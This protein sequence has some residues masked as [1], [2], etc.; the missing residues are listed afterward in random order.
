[1]HSFDASTVNFGEVA[2]HTSLL[3]KH[4][5]HFLI[6]PSTVRDLSLNF[7]NIRLDDRHNSHFHSRGH[8]L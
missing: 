7:L 4:Y 8:K 6:L 2:Q 5:W 3:N 1:M